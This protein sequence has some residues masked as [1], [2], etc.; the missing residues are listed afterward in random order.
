M[1]LEYYNGQHGI[2]VHDLRHTACV[3]ALVKMV[4][5][6]KDP[7]CCLPIL[8]VFMGHHDTESTEYYLRLTQEAYP[9]IIK[10]DKAYTSSISD[11]IERA[12]KIE[13]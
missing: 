5:A 1:G 6:G 12:L 8:S 7:Y 10:M 11:I 13:L 4:R 3:H 9:D 2:R